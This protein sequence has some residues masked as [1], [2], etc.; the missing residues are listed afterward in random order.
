M[1]DSPDQSYT[2][3]FTA[4]SSLGTGLHIRAVA[5]SLRTHLFRVD[6]GSVGMI[7]PRS[8]LGSDY[9]KDPSKPEIKFQYV[10][11]GTTYYGQWV[12]VPVTF[13]VPLGWDGSG[14]YPTTRVEVFAVDTPTEFTKGMLGIGFGIN[15]KADGGKERNPLLRLT[16]KGVNLSPGYTITSANIQIG[17]TADNTRGFRL[18]NLTKNARGSDWMQPQSKAVLSDSEGDMPLLG[19]RPFL[20][21][22]GIAGMILWLS[23]GTLDLPANEA[24]RSGIEISIALPD[25]GS[26]L[27]YT[28]TTGEPIQPMAPASVEWKIGNGINTGANVLAGYDYLYDSDQGRI[29]FRPQSGQA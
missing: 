2:I 11:D 22:T 8:V 10:S 17:L 1:A 21:D 26:V 20:M 12:N 6:T 15:G 28:F 29:G 3:P 23:E 5:G 27:Q 9:P 4:D 13:G 24:F 16:Y 14:D 7:V 19:D 18:I 25:D